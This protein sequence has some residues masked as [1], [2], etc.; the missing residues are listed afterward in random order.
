MSDS[1]FYK[2]L[3]SFRR[4]NWLWINHAKTNKREN[5]FSHL[6]QSIFVASNLI[7]LSRQQKLMKVRKEGIFWV[8][9]FSL[10]PLS[11]LL[12]KSLFDHC[13]HLLLPFFLFSALIFPLI[14][15]NVSSFQIIFP[16]IHIPSILLN[17]PTISMSVS[18]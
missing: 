6:L 4:R 2:F 11:P 17:P 10:I 3:N 12:T 15:N 13:L 9:P 18:G 8:T 14:I 7:S 5:L 1:S 16:P